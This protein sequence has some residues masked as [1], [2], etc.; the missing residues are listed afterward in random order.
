MGDELNDQKLNEFFAGLEGF[1]KA[2]GD[3]SQCP[4]MKCPVHYRNDSRK[5]EDNGQL[6]RISYKG[7]YA[8]YSYNLTDPTGL[9]V[10]RNEFYRVDDG[11]L[12][13]HFWSMAVEKPGTSQDVD[14]MHEKY[15]SSPEAT[16]GL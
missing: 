8:L 2:V 7:N 11:P 14:S 9:E 1:L 5:M 10:I 6:I 12:D 16:E 15:L 4:D 13:G 3:V